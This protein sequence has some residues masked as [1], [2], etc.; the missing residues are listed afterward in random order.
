MW[1][2]I[3]A[4]LSVIQGV[5]QYSQLRSAGDAAKEAGKYQANLALQE[6]GQEAAAAQQ[7]AIL[8]RRRGDIVAGSRRS[9]ESAS[10]AIDPT[11][12]GEARLEADIGFDVLSELFAGEDAEA[13]ARQRAAGFR[14]SGDTQKAALRGEALQSLVGGFGRAAGFAGQA[15]L[16]SPGTTTAGTASQS[17]MAALYGEGG[18]SGYGGAT[19]PRG[20]AT[21]PA[22]HYSGIGGS[23]E[24]RGFTRPR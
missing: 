13:A 12:Y 3:A 10:G 20:F 7:R 22:P 18:F 1:F 14:Y 9:R 8:A 2:A 6:G 19:G 23:F 17:R 11:G 21:T 15:G 24:G 5:M 4:A 16:F